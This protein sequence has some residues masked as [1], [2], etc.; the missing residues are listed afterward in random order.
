MRNRH[1][2]RTAWDAIETHWDELLRRY[3]ARMFEA[4]LQPVAGIVDDDF[5]KRTVDWLK[6]HPIEEVSRIT[7]QVL[8]FQAVTL[9]LAHRVQGR[10]VELLG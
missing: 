2:S 10:L 5:A 3:P 1:A 6:A 7:S 4:F 8:E 9:G